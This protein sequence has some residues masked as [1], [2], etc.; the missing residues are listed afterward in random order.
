MGLYQKMSWIHS[1]WIAGALVALARGHHTMMEGK[2]L[3]N[4]GYHLCT[5]NETRKESR[6]VYHA[7]PYIVQRHCGSW[8][9]WRMCNVT[10]YKMT[11]WPE[12]KEVVREVTRC[13]HGFVHMG[14]YCVLP[15]NR[16]RE[17]TT[18][19][20]FCPTAAEKSHDGCQTCVWDIDCPGWQKCCQTLNRSRC[21][22]P[23]MFTHY[24]ANGGWRLNVTVTVKTDYDVM[25]ALDKGLLNHT[26]LLHTMVSGALNS[27]DISVQYL[28]SCPVVPYR[29]ATSLIIGCDAKLSLDVTTAKLHKLLRDISEVSSVTVEDVD[30]CAHTALRNCSPHAECNNTAASYHCSC[31]HGYTDVLPQNAGASCEVYQTP[32]NATPC[33]NGQ[34]GSTSQSPSATP[35]PTVDPP[36]WSASAPTTLQTNATSN[37]STPPP[38]EMSTCAPPKLTQL[39]S[40]HITGTSFCLSWS[41]LPESNQTSYLVDLKEGSEFIIHLVTNET[42]VNM[43]DLDPGVLYSVTITP[44]ACDAQGESQL[45][46]VKTA[47]QNLKATA[48]VTNVNFTDDFLNSSSQAYFNFSKSIKEEIYKSLSSELKELVESGKVRIEIISLSQ[49]SVVVNFSIVYDASVTELNVSSAVLGSLLNSTRYSVDEHSTSVSDVDECASGLNDC[50]Q[51]AT[52]NN[53]W[54]SY[55]C[56]CNDGFEDMDSDWPGRVCGDTTTSSLA[57]STTVPVTTP[58]LAP[59]TTVPATTSTLAQPTTVPATTSSLAQP[60]TVPV[61]TPSL[62]PS[63]TVPATTPSLA[64]STT[65]PATTSTLAQPTTVPAT[66]SS[67]A[68]PTTVPVST[69]SLAPSTTV[70]ATTSSSAQPTTVPATTSTLAQPTTV[71]VTTPSLA[72]STTVPATTSTLAQPT[73]VPATTTSSAQP[74]TQ[75][76]TTSS[77]AQPTTILP[78]TSSLAL[79]TTEPATSSSL[80]PPITVPINYTFM[81]IP[82]IN[83]GLPSISVEC[84][85]KAIMVTVAKDFL[86][87]KQISLPSLH[88]GQESN[89]PLDLNDT[90]VRLTAAWNDT[91]RFSNDSYLTA[92]V[93][94]FNSPEPLLNSTKGIVHTLEVPILCAYRKSVFISANFGDMGYNMNIDPIS[95]SGSFKVIMQLLNGSGTSA[96]P[97]N[98]TLSPDEEVVV[99]VSMN[100]SAE[101]MRLI[102]SKCWATPTRNIVDNPSYIFLNR[103]CPLTDSYT[104]I[105]SNGNSSSSSLSVRI[106]SFV[107]LDVVYLKC[108][109]HICVEMGSATCV[110]DCSMSNARLARTVDS[111]VGSSGALI[112][113][114]EY[115]L[116]TESDILQVVGFSFLGICIMVIFLAGFTCIVFYQRNRIGHYN[117]NIKPKQDDFTFHVFNT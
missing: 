25:M 52:C 87:T 34:T 5:F 98:Y 41:G 108:Q 13:C 105:I 35:G 78:T 48:K 106:F 107:E 112:R 40:S 67:L 90:H 2:D 68:Q 111:L 1:M 115:S 43:T 84:S 65:V 14:P 83:K 45:L 26:Q 9:P 6:L 61:S 79:P 89:L 75:P 47:A 36:W 74:T 59:S 109:V 38:E 62:A 66:T 8:L 19:P 82:N 37:T 63:T 81:G 30:E 117:F 76:A 32:T 54:G 56:V 29:T 44:C 11:L 46:N 12:Y 95:A 88:L 94:L 27:S 72:P 77:L 70:P 49:G 116:E 103:G 33:I 17:F 3:L 110:P 15:L 50:S 86:Q 102:I 51:N 39:S 93:T 53:T 55:T 114:H 69:P 22:D 100:T 91:N 57:P 104:A 92:K 64:P 21:V 80:A 101:E 18:K 28:S 42:K 7:V 58:S 23:A 31:R 73:T 20:G 60:T 10:L 24:V 71:P 16:T 97:H 113:E 96:L 99:K 4:T 85:P